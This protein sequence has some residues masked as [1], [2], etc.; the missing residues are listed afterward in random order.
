MWSLRVVV[1]GG[2]GQPRGLEDQLDD[3]AG[4]RNGGGVRGAGDLDR[5]PR[6]GALSLEALEGGVNDVVFLVD[7]E[8]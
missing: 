3:R 1:L 7:Q 2:R 4:L 6:P 8:P 5:A